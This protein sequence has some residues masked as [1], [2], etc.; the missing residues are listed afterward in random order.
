MLNRAV[1]HALQWKY[2]WYKDFGAVAVFFIV[3]HVEDEP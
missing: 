2:R 1:R 3:N